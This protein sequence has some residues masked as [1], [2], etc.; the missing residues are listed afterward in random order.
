[1]LVKDRPLKSSATFQL[2]PRRVLTILTWEGSSPALKS[3]L[4]NSHT[5]VVPVYQ[6]R[7]HPPSVPLHLLWV[8]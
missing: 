3:I 8:G 5:D 6:V 7:P 2:F 1:M 4:L